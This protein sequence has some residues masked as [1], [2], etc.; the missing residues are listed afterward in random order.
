[1]TRLVK[2]AAEIQ[3]MLDQ[4]SW[5]NCLIGGL[6]LQ[7]WGQPRLTRD[8]DLTVMTGFGG[9]EALI[10]LMLA[11]FTGRR[12]DVQD[13][14]LR[15]RVLLLK[16]TDGI[17]I[18]VALGALPFEERAVQRAS[19][20]PFLA[21]CPLRTCSAEDLVVMKAFAGREQDWLDL[22]TVALRQG[23]QL[24]WALILSEL[25]PLAEAKPEIDILGELERRRRKL[26]RL[27]E[28]MR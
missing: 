6:A 14:A 19:D 11:R 17:G 10:S 24:D 21:D 1:M 13:F 23:A 18:D 8:V 16:S 2:L 5:R 20:Y 27:T 3:T 7:R 12:G 22:E 9:E 4:A 26:A 28:D 15:Y 25:A